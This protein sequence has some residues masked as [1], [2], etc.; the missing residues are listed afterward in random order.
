MTG[1]FFKN[2][3]IW[4]RI[5]NDD[6]LFQKPIPFHHTFITSGVSNPVSASKYNAVIAVSDRR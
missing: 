3:M 6:I 2:C 1:N 5:F 4:N